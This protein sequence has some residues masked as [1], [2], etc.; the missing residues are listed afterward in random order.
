MA[1]YRL[2]IGSKNYSTWSLRAGL[3]AKHLALDFEEILIQLD[4]PTTK[5]MIA[6]YSPSGRVPVLFHQGRAIWD[7]IAIA[8][9]LNEQFP[10]AQLWPA[11]TAARAVARSISAEMHSGFAPLRQNLPMDIRASHPGHN[12]PAEVR[13]EV[14]RIT[15]IW[16]ECRARWGRGGDFL[17]GKFTIADAFYAPVVNR[18]VTWDVQLDAACDEYAEAILALPPMR[19][20]HEAALAEEP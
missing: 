8:E 15:S 13:A 6:Q 19:E 14:A 12:P 2:V 7:S 17:F 18:F 20:W 9:Y 4:R 1:E 5:E 16:S 3:V 10:K 11:D